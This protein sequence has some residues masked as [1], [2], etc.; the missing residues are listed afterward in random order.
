MASNEINSQIKNLENILFAAVA[1]LHKLS[2]SPEKPNYSGSLF[3]Q[4]DT[5]YN[6]AADYDG[7][8]GSM[9]LE[10]A[11][12]GAFTI[13]ASGIE[14]GDAAECLSE[15]IKDRTP[16]QPAKI[17][18]KRVISPAFNKTSAKASAMEA[19][20]RDL[21]KRLGIE[22]LIASEQRKI[23]ALKKHAAMGLAA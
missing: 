16:S 23:Y 14:W 8:L 6:P 21:P 20:W 1:K 19:Y 2:P 13:A 18:A 22:R 10:S 5:K 17:G 9:V 11:L 15:F 12:G 3:V 7:M 4:T